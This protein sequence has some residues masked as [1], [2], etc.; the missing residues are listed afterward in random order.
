VTVVNAK[1]QLN[2]MSK[3]NYVVTVEMMAGEHWIVSVRQRLR[4]GYFD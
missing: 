2:V 4:P 1:E 3:L